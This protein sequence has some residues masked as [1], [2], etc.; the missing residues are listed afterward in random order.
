MRWV[1]HYTHPGDTRYHVF[2]FRESHHARRFE[3]RCAA[4]GIAF[5]RHEEEGE[6]MFGVA[7]TSFTEALRAN[8]LVHAEFRSHFIP[9]KG[10]RWGLL[11][12]TAAVLGLALM[13]WLTS[14]T[15]H[16]Q[17][18]AGLPWEL[19]VV[20]RVHVPIDALGM[21]PTTVEGQGIDAVWSPR[22]GSDVGLRIHRRLNDGWTLGGGVEWIRR[23]HD[24]VVAYSNDSLAL[25]ALDSLPG[26]RS[27][28][29]RIP[30]LGGIR[31]PLGWN[32]LEVQSSIGVGVEWKTSETIVSQL[33]QT[34]GQDHIVQ[35]YQ[36][37]TRYV[38]MPVIA[39][40]G[41]QRRATRKQPGW[42][43]GWHWSSPI[44]RSAW[45]ENTW[46]SGS[47]AGIARSFLNL[48]N[49]GVDI[50]LVLPE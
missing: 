3:E 9:H 10:W 22:F 19:D 37:R 47:T 48:V 8:H 36:G 6:V 1:N 45:A 15:A 23:E 21:V 2:V 13:G 32:D 16:G 46:S 31:I 27:L 42:Y 18:E 35:A 7:K 43:L 24:S 28:A 34:E 49:T 26:M 20:A 29:Y 17:V 50:R 30:F 5:E 40:I 41:I 44:G 39:E 4:E 11:V 33:V 38:T 12:F 25:S 14:T